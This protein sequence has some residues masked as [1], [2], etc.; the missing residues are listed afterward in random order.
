VSLTV[1]ETQENDDLRFSVVP[2]FKLCVALFLLVVSSSFSQSAVSDSSLEHPFFNEIL[3]D[4]ASDG[5]FFSISNPM[6]SDIAI[7]NWSVS[8][9]EGSATFPAC[10]IAS[11]G[12]LTVARNATRFHEQNHRIADFSIL[13]SSLPS[14][15]LLMRGSF[16]LAND[17]DEMYLTDRNG[18][19]IDAVAFGSSAKVAEL[20]MYWHG[21]QIPS[22][23]RSRILVRQSDVDTDSAADW[24]ALRD[25]RPGQSDFDPVTD[26]CSIA[27]LILPEH[28]NLIIDAI[29][30]AR[31]SLLICTYEF[32]SPLVGSSIIDLLEKGVSVKMLLEGCPA[33]GISNRSKALLPM[34]EEAGARICFAQPS[35]TKDL[36][37][38]YSYVH[39]KYIVIDGRTSIVLSENLVSSIFDAELG[40]GNRGWATVL[41]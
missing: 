37:R 27:A 12:T 1:A 15:R 6:A 14:L 17:G 9:G 41:N 3:F 18:K 8:D 35:S 33:G 22:P 32:D 39:A 4:D 30:S 24:L 40:H 16:R 11:H 19:T 23:G 31:L 10:S 20:G 7:G 34:L 36:P 28:S 25:Y 29:N 13:P 26:R 2:Y 5:E 38:R 21:P